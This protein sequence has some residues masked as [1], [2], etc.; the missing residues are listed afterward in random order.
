M[1]IFGGL[2]GWGNIFLLLQSVS[3]CDIM[4]LYWG[5][6][7]LLFMFLCSI[8]GKI[9]KFSIAETFG[10]EEVLETQFHH[11]KENRS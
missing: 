3:S 4:F 11:A 5:N 1:W 10:T 9:W 7:L 8:G 2:G 6:Q